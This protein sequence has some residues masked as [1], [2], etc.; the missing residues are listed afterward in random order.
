MRRPWGARGPRVAV[1]TDS[2]ASLPPA[3]AARCGVH[4]VPL[5]VL[6]DGERFSEG[7]DLT[8]AR[9]ASVL[10]AGARVTTSQPPPAAFAR[11]YR[12]AVGRGA[13]EIVSVHLSGE[14]SGTVRA[15]E[16]AAM[17]APVPVHVVD[18][19]TVVMGLGFA[20]LAAV[21]EVEAAGQRRQ[22]PVA[23]GAAV[24]ERARAVAAS[25][26]V[27]FLV[28]TLEH[29]RRGGR[30]SATAAALGTV[31]GMRPILTVRAGRIEVAEKVR[32][33]RA[34]R[35][36]LEQLAIAEVTR[37]GTARVAVHHL[38]DPMTAEALARQVS[39]WC[40]EAAG[41]VEVAE[42]SAVIAAHVGPGTLA[43]VVTDD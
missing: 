14:L 30:L 2:T 8:S 41:T 1:V 24:A 26:S 16:L 12:E 18:S 23:D 3:L 33:R 20:V 35:E 27:Y 11:A 5:D 17:A 15:A 34:A 10:R 25:T 6:V 42:I 29:L 36:R 21:A 7:V 28:D 39:S 22:Q 38:D 19:R 40:G 43:V 31:L 32:T 4:V 9:L 37:R 13:R